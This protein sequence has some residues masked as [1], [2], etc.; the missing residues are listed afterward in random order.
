MGDVFLVNRFL[1]GFLAFLL[2]LYATH[3]DGDKSARR[4][5]DEL[6][7]WRSCVSMR[8]TGMEAS[9]KD[10]SSL[11]SNI[12]CKNTNKIIVFVSA[13]CS[14]HDTCDTCDTW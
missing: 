8:P 3:W 12:T 14:I 1:F 10:V 13:A 6:L 11:L 5:P 4:V 9:A 7:F 2:F